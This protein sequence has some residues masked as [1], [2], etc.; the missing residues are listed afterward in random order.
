MNP[1][2][3]DEADVPHPLAAS[4]RDMARDLLNTDWSEHAHDEVIAIDRVVEA[5][6]RVA[7]HYRALSRRRDCVHTTHRFVRCAEAPTA[8]PPT[9]PAPSEPPPAECPTSEADR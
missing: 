1:C 4:F 7:E 5:L 6:Q 2:T 9:A 3:S 8:A